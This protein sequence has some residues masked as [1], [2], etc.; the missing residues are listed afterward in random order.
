MRLASVR[1][2]RC[3]KAGRLY[4]LVKSEDHK[5]LAGVR[6]QVAG[7][8]VPVNPVTGRFDFSIPGDHLI[9]QLVLDADGPG[10]SCSAPQCSPELE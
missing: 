10:C 6:L 5:C 9:D 3:R 1:L 7:L 4:G 2:C 8:V